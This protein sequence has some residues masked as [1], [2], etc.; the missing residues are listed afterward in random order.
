MTRFKETH[1][2]PET[3]LLGIR[4][5][6]AGFS[7]FFK[8][9]SLHEATDKTVEFERI[10]SPDIQKTIQYS[11]AYLNHFFL[12]K[13]SKPKHILLPVVADIQNNKGLLNV[14]NLAQRHFTTVRQLERSFKQYIGI[15]PK[16]FI[17]FVRYQ[18]TLAKIQSNT[19]NR[20]LLDIAFECGYY[21]HAHLTNEVKKYTGVAPSEL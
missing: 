12:H 20:S 10:L 4:F 18:L 21:D 2:N 8:Y 1:M 19:S 11:T 9:M 14:P 6:P 15:S 7:A 3:K 17:N 13:L 16:E 5:K